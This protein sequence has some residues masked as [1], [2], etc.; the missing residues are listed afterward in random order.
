MS[1]VER[2][3]FLNPDGSPHYVE[4][5]QDPNKDLTAR[6]IK[7]KQPRPIEELAGQLGVGVDFIRTSIDELREQGYGISEQEGVMIRTKTAHNGTIF[8]ASQI[9]DK[10][11]KF[12]IAGDSH[13]S[14][15]KERTDELEAMYDV[16]KSEGVTAVFHPGDITEGVG[17]YRGQELEVKHYGQEAQIDYAVETYPRR[18]GLKTYFITGNHD[19]RAYERGGVDPGPSIERQ[20]DDME[21]LG[22]ATAEVMLPNGVKMELLHPAGGISYALSYKA[23]K[24]INNLAPQDVP[25]LMVW[26]HYHTS[27]YMHYRNVHFVQAPAFKD[28]GIWEKRLGLNPTIGGWIVEGRIS[29]YGNVDRFKPELFTFDTKKR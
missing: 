22:Q 6:L 17:V 4:P 13:L 11:F 29:D 12:G 28:A 8:D 7:E 21:Y 14:S 18:D 23:Q 3:Y 26:G 15:K 2:P 24:Y 5:L 25:D 9:I 27:F 10:Q 1:S 20:R 19:L 16:F